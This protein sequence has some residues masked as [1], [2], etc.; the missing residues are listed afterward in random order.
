VELLKGPEPGEAVIL[1]ASG[2]R[3]G[4]AVKAREPR[5]PRTA[6]LQAVPQLGR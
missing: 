6:G 2:A 1:P 4:D 3:E 5:K